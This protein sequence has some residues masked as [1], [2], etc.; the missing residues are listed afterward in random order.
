MYSQKPF[1]V[2]I[3][4]LPDVV[5]L[6]DPE[7]NVTTFL[8]AVTIADHKLSVVSPRLWP[9]ELLTKSLLVLSKDVIFPDRAEISPLLTKVIHMLLTIRS[10]SYEWLFLMPIIKERSWCQWES[11]DIRNLL[12]QKT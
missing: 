1:L 10:G 12:F 11:E 2:L 7:R 4:H 6:C 5:T 8:I 3:P 9:R